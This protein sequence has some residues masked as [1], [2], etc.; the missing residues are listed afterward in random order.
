MKDK[1]GPAFPGQPAYVTTWENNVEVTKAINNDGMTRRDLIAMH[2]MS[3]LMVVKGLD[4]LLMFTGY[5]RDAA[6]IAK[7]AAEALLEVLND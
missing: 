5:E 7:E 4:G 3:D 2:V 6:R 1:S